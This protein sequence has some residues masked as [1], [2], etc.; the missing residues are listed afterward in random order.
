MLIGID[1]TGSAYL[2]MSKLDGSIPPEERQGYDTDMKTSFVRELVR[3]YSGP[4]GGMYFR[5]PGLTGDECAEIARQCMIAARVPLQL[6]SVIHL[7]G[8]S[9]GGAIAIALS[10]QIR[11]E[12]PDARIPVMA[13]FD[14]VDRETKLADLQ[15]IPGNVEIA[16]HAR[17]DRIVGSRFYF[18]NCGT[19]AEPPCK[20]VQLTF[21]TTHG[22]MGGVPWI[23]QPPISERLA[24]HGYIS[25]IFTVANDT[26]HIGEPIEVATDYWFGSSSAPS[27]L[28]NELFGAP[29]GSPSFRGQTEN[30][31]SK[32]VHKW[33]WANL[34][35]HGIVH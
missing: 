19:A 21:V 7:A 10:Q 3:E 25:E 15:T 26:Y 2:G 1:G 6:G 5:G 13:L 22:G 12:F 4:G 31:Q 29:F 27:Q 33:M 11:A 34:R 30:Q 16:F 9:R 28:A 24:T 14:A 23:G 17:R 20:L 18:G 8:Y 32:L 35:K